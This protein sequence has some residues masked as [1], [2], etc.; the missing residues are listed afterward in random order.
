LP[1]CR[2][3]R[4]GRPGHGAGWLGY[5]Y[6]YDTALARQAERGQVQMRLYAQALESELAR[7]DYVPSLLSLDA[8]IDALCAIRARPR[9]WRRPMPT[10]PR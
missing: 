4:A 1:V 8:R 9:A 6:T 3:A 2:P 7:Y 5:R 10:W